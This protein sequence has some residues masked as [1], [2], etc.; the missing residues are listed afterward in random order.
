MRLADQ[1]I[2]VYD[3]RFTGGDISAGETNYTHGD[4][5]LYII[6]TDSSE[7]Y[8]IVYPR[9]KVKKELMT[10]LDEG[11]LHGAN[12]QSLGFTHVRTRDNWW[13]RILD[14]FSYVPANMIRIDKPS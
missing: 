6:S 12:M 13:N 4:S 10:A 7:T 3:S 1:V 5:T 2:S 8:G 9:I 11:F 14:I